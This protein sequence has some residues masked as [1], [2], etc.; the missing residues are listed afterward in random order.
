MSALVPDDFIVPEELRHP[1]FR[2]RML[3]ATDA[4]AD[5]AAVMASQDRL[6][7]GSPHGWPRPGFTLA[8]NRAD[9]ERHERE[10]RERGAF[11]YTMVAPDGSEVLGCVYINPPGA[12]SAGPPRHDAEVYMWVRDEQHPGLTG[13]LFE[14]VDAWLSERWPFEQVR[15]VRTEYYLNEEK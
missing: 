5:Y 2:L 9:L 10:F 1:R 11:A 13:M 4:E 3:A 15:Y 7:A 12:D 6:R 14:A 8:E